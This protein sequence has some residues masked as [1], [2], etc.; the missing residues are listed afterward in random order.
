MSRGLGFVFFIAYTD[1]NDDDDQRGMCNEI[2]DCISGLEYL[3]AITVC[4]IKRFIQT[5]L[6]QLISQ[7]IASSSIHVLLFISGSISE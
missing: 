3:P 1:N 5:N 6:T 7:M 4:F 2:V